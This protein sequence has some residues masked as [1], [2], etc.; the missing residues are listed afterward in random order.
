M[1]TVLPR[2]PRL[3][4][5]NVLVGFDTCDDAGVYR[6]SPECALVQTVDF[7]TPIVDDPYDFGAI[8]AANGLTQTSTLTIGQRLVIPSPDSPAGLGA[9]P[10]GTM[11]TAAG[12][13]GATP[14]PSTTPAASRNSSP[15][16]L[17]SPPRAVPARSC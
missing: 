6:L 14:V 10:L 4:D 7:F 13:P 8:A 17:P 1:D 9:A 16:P 5:D 11:P 15:A 3:K 2:I 12:T